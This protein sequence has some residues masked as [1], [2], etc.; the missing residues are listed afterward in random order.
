MWYNQSVSDYQQNSEGQY[1][2]LSEAALMVQNRGLK[3]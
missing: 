3:K 2:R 1:V